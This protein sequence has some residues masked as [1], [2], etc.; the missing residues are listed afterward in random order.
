MEITKRRTDMKK[1]IWAAGVATLCLLGL[2]ACDD[3]SSSPN[4]KGEQDCCV[5][6]ESDEEK[7]QNSGSEGMVAEPGS[8]S[9]AQEY[10]TG[11]PDYC[12]VVSEDPFV[13]N[14]NYM[15]LPIT[16]RYSYNNGTVTVEMVYE[17]PVVGDSMCVYEKHNYSYTNVR[18]NGD[19]ITADYDEEMSER[20]YARLVKMYKE[21]CLNYKDWGNVEVDVQ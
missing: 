1:V 12:E 16:S 17:T 19:K 11:L 4:A 15:G 9:S 21:S 2:V 7:N 18:C 6:Y 3:S 5:V 20:D 14:M 10:R 13:M 8:S